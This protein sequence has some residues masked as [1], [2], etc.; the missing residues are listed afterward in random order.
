MNMRCATVKICNGNDSYAV[1]NE[2]D[3]D[4]EK[5]E[6]YEESEESNEP[7]EG[8]KSWLQDELRKLNIEFNDNDKKDVLKSLLDFANKTQSEA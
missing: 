7:K 4:S 5:H 8:S 3:F 6:M 2:S 1:I